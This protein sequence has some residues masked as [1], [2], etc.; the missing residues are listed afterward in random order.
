MPAG[1][2]NGPG[3]EAELLAN[4]GLRLR[5][6][7]SDRDDTGD[8]LNLTVMLL[9]SILRFPS[10]V[11]SQAV[12]LYAKNRPVSYGCFLGEYRQKYGTDFGVPPEEV[13]RRMDEGIAAGWKTDCSRVFGAIRW[14][15]REEAGANP[16]LAEL[17]RPIVRA[18]LE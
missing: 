3:G 10:G 12:Q 9:M 15:H 11:S 16:E 8:D 7:A 14:Y 13:R 1:D 17:Y 6:T 4:V 5:A 18:Y 2:G